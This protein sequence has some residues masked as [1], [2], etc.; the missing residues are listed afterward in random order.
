MRDEH[1]DKVH[2]ADEACQLIPTTGDMSPDHSV[3]LILALIRAN[4]V[5]AVQSL[6]DKLSLADY[7]PYFRLLCTEVAILGSPEMLRI[8]YAKLIPRSDS[9]FLFP[10]FLKSAIESGNLSINEW[11]DGD[12]VHLTAPRLHPERYICVVVSALKSES[13]HS[14]MKSL[15]PLTIRIYQESRR[16][17]QCFQPGLVA[18]TRNCPRR[19]DALIALWEK[20][21]KID[22]TKLSDLSTGLSSVAATTFSLKLAGALLEFGACVDGHGSG[23]KHPTPL[24]RAASR[25]SMESAIFMRFL[26]RHGADPNVEYR[27]TAGYEGDPKHPNAR[28]GRV[29]HFK[30]VQLSEEV[31]PKEISRWLGKSWEEVL[32]ESRE[33]RGAKGTSIEKENC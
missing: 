9:Q 12:I 33:A 17:V 26:L 13:F 2:S 21:E 32:E 18:A 29:Y 16:R 15:E 4:K 27:K 31:G 8:M 30:A 14:T 22:R 7:S 25:D 24:Q 20:L 19:E 23:K 1:L 6:L 10:I 28:C 11:L 3:S 5:Q